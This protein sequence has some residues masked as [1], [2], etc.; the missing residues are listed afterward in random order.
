MRR[1]A[2]KYNLRGDDNITVIVLKVS[3]K[4]NRNNWFAWL[5]SKFEKIM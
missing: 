4:K 5:M 3:D 1:F 2:V